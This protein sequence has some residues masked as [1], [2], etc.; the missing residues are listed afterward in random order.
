MPAGSRLRSVTATS[1]HKAIQHDGFRNTNGAG[2]HPRRGP[3]GIGSTPAALSGLAT[4]CQQLSP[5]FP[6][7]RDLRRYRDAGLAPGVLRR[8]VADLGLRPARLARPRDA[9]WLSAGRDHRLSVHGDTELDRTA[10]DQ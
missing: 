10:A 6:V 3:V 7:W 9:L 2:S 8:G 5:V 4:V 1:L